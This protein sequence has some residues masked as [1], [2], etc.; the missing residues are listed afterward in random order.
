MFALIWIVLSVN[1]LPCPFAIAASAGTDEKPPKFLIV[2]AG[3]AGIAAASK[4]L[5]KG[6]TDIVILEAQNRIGGRVHTIPFGAN[7]IDL[8]AQWCGGDIGN[9]VYELVKGHFQ[10]GD[11]GIRYSNSH[12]YTSDGHVV[13][14]KLYSKAM[15][16]ADEILND[17]EN[18][19]KTNKSL[20][21][22]FQINYHKALE[23]EEFKDVDKE[24]AELMTDLNAK[25][26][27]ALYASDSWYD[28][29]ANL[30]GEGPGTQG[31]YQQYTWKEHGF[32][33][34]LDFLMKK[35][36]DP[37]KT[38]PVEEKI[39]LNKEVTNIDWTSNEVVVTC[40]D[41]SEYRVDHVIVT[42]S[43]GYLK[44][45]H[46]TLF[47]PPLPAKKVNAI[48]NTGF[49]TLGK[50]FLEFKEPF[51][52]TDVNDWA[53]YSF[54]WKKEDLDNV[55]G[56]EKE[57][58]IDITN[59]LRVDAQPNVILAFTAGKKIRKFE[60]ISD[61]QLI[62][63]CMWLLEKFLGRTLPRAINVQ[64]SHWLTNKYFL[65]SYSFGSMATQENDVALGKDLAETLSHDGK[66]VVLLAGE[67]TDESNSGYVH[68]AVDSGWRA[69]REIL[70]YYPVVSEITGA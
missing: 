56:T 62:D 26:M 7:N 35:L 27:A 31:G 55:T 63:D 41:G 45:H 9:V 58:L 13:D 22:Y 68:G 49:G 70:H 5:E 29:S 23:D 65:G 39:H 69:A 3:A 53:A 57:W 67:A 25:G 42:V 38:L 18:M 64:R 33:I 34:V 28:L 48:E 40:A 2:G 21:E 15:N 52:P 11:T 6:Y 54:L 50:I 12:C 59:F 20:G 61:S 4:L 66:P 44:K 46:Q 19:A 24:F 10:F 16:L 1:I 51:W 43:L 8:G 60:E 47:T 30:I 37:S 14:P 17:Y 36:P 32:K